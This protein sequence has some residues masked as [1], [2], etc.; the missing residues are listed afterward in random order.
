MF[1]TVRN[2]FKLKEIRSRI[3]YTLL[4]LVVV[5]IGTQLPIPGVNGSYFSEWFSGNS[6]SAFGFFDAI[7]G[8]SFEKMSVFALNI[9]PYITSS[10]IIQLLTIAIPK[11]EELQKDGEEG[12]KKMTAITRY[13]T[14][15]LALMESLAMAIGFGK[16]GLLLE[17]NALN[18]IT[19]VVTLTAGST[20]IMWIGERITENGV[21]N[22]ISIV[23]TINIISRIPQ[24]LTLLF[25]QFVKGKEI[26]F[27]V[28]NLAIIIAIIIAVTVLTV[29]LQGAER[30]IPVQ[31][32]RKVQG[33]KQ[34]G[35]QSSYIP[36]KVNTA[37]VIPIIFAQSLFMFPL[38]IMQL[39]GKSGGNGVG[40]TILKMLNQSNW[41]DFKEPI[42]SI[43]LIVYIVLVIAF[44]YFYTSIT[45]NPLEIADNMKKQGGFIPG[46]RPG[47]PT[48]EYLTKIL[49][50]IIF[51]GAVGLV[52][53]AII[54]IFFEG[55]FNASISFGGTSLIIIVG[56][57]IETLKQI[58][59]RMLVRNY[60]GFLND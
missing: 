38:I 51:I 41:C 26:A 60:K 25:E 22:G 9:T 40:G 43:G 19:A 18:I 46:I 31:Y 13:L 47:K 56:V 34:I 17:Y 11:L 48:S 39:L 58:E 50:Y 6:G 20:V 14:V 30:R 16:S 3:I 21:G 54:P 35:G 1:E 49:N 5:R 12:R 29:T 44:A 24:D 32:S 27:Q 7:T 10:I 2:A 8:G 36:L 52:I 59:S 23:L 15:A 57:I 33:R 37:G 42:Y 4:M 28:L 55:A 45:F 53:V